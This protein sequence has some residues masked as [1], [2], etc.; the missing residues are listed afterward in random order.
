MTERKGYIRLFQG[1]SESAPVTILRETAKFYVAFHAARPDPRRLSAQRDPEGETTTMTKREIKHSG[2]TA[3]IELR[4][5]KGGW[6]D[7]WWFCSDVGEFPFAD[8]R[9]SLEDAVKKARRR[10]IG[11]P[12]PADHSQIWG[13]YTCADCG[14]KGVKL[15]RDYQT[16]LDAQTLRCRACAEKHEGKAKRADGD[17]IGWSVPAVPTSD[18]STFWGYTSVPIAAVDWWKALPETVEGQ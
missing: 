1:T 15:W 5:G 14:A 17:S 3:T 12:P 6:R 13:G 11:D 8:S 7:C 10:F 4:P 9:T 2:Y 16:F 18:G